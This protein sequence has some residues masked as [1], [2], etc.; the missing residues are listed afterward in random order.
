MHLLKPHQSS[1]DAS[2]PMLQQAVASP[3]QSDSHTPKS[4]RTAKT[5]VLPFGRLDLQNFFRRSYGKMVM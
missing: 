1:T 4:Q 5:F 3:V 2:N